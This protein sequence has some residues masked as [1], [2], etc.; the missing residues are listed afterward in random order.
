MT[1]MTSIMNIPELEVDGKKD[2]T[3]PHHYMTVSVARNERNLVEDLDLIPTDQLFRTK[4]KRMVN[5]LKLC[6]D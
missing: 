4:Y 6:Q 2:H 1:T 3:T 5:K